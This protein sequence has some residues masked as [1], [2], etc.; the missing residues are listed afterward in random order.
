MA[1]K[2]ISAY[3][4]VSYNAVLMFSNTLYIYL[5]VQE[6]ETVYLSLKNQ[7]ENYALSKCEV[8]KGSEKKT[9]G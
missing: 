2:M 4:T 8:K 5:L 9:N 7:Q 3:R 1:L 6:I